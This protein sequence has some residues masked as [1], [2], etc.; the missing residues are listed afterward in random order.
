MSHTDE[1]RIAVKTFLD[2]M[3]YQTANL[4]STMQTD[5]L[6]QGLQDNS[7]N[8]IQKTFIKSLIKQGIMKFYLAPSLNP[9]EPSVGL[10]SKN[11]KAIMYVALNTTDK[12]HLK[13]YDSPY[14][15]DLL[16]IHSFQKGEGRKL[17]E[18]FKE[19]HKET[20][21]PGSLWTESTEN[22]G[23]FK[24]FGFEDLGRIGKENEFLM[25]LP[26]IKD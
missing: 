5:N 11:L 15:L 4:M 2:M 10:V 20:D 13:V 17:M 23:Y 24:Q 6:Q 26:K 9:A 14:V 25:K 1:S 19:I 7:L 21:V 16:H 3:N 22:V 12:K 18:A 8:S